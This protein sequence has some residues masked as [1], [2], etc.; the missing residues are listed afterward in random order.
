MVE[1]HVNLNNV[2]INR[3]YDELKDDLNISVMNIREKSF[4]V[5][6]IRSKWVIYLFK[7]RE[8]LEK[9]KRKK[10]EYMA[11][12]LAKQSNPSLIRL[13]DEDS[14]QN[15]DV[16]KKLNALQK[17]CVNV[18]EFLEYVVAIMND[19]G[20]TIKNSIDILKLEQT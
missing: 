12:K 17:Q 11:S 10:S 1:K 16:I 3:Y 9:V 15:S 4:T 8:N 14:L 20:F 7:E 13:K 19:Y 18:V 2:T 5:S 6:S